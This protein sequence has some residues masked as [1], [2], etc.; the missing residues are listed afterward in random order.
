MLTK[1]N[2]PIL[3]IA[4][5]TKNGNGVFITTSTYLKSEYFPEGNPN[6]VYFHTAYLSEWY[7]Y[8]FYYPFTLS[9][10]LHLLARHFLALFICSY[11]DLFTFQ[12]IIGSCFQL[13]FINKTITL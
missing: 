10:S 12:E 9:F 2:Q 5:S 6:A 1:D 3:G 13:F 11:F 8:L 4:I 7:Y